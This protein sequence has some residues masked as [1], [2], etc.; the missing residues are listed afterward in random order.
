MHKPVLN[1]QVSIT[2]QKPRM[3]G[4]DLFTFSAIKITFFFSFHNLF[5]HCLHHVNQVSYIP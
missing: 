3:H 4:M 1:T 5:M 2:L